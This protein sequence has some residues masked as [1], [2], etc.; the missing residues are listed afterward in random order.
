[1]KPKWSFAIWPRVRL[2]EREQTIRDRGFYPVVQ[3]HL[4]AI[5]KTGDRSEEV[6]TITAPTLV[7][8]GLMMVWY[9]LSMANTLRPDSG[10]RA[11]C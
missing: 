10:G 11:S 2:D 3:R 4:M 1:M 6:A 5:F 7:L 8:H 9:R